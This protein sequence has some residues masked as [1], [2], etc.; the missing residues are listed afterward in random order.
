MYLLEI[1][2]NIGVVKKAANGSRTRDLSTTNA[3]LYLLSYSSAYN[4][5]TILERKP[6]VKIFLINLST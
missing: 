5:T 2:L 1:G 4:N 6:F 3:A